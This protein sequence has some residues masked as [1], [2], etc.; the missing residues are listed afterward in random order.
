[1]TSSFL[2]DEFRNVM[3]Y[4]QPINVKCLML[5]VFKCFNLDVYYTIKI[6]IKQALLCQKKRSLPKGK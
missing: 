5:P 1:M 6:H 4:Y 3:I 2:A